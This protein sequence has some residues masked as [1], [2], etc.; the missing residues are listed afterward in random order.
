MKKLKFPLIKKNERCF[1]HPKVDICQICGTDIKSLNHKF[2]HLNGDAMQ[3]IGDIDDGNAEMAIDCAG[4][5]ELCYH[6]HDMENPPYIEI[7]KNSGWGQFEF[8][9]CSLDCL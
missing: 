2:F 1:P 3:V 8:N 4:F 6:D 9:F 7:V 5:L